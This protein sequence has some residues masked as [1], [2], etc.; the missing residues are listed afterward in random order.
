MGD[1]SER[2]REALAAIQ[3]AGT[4]DELESL[5]VQLLGR[6]GEITARLKAVG[7]LPAAQRPAAGKAVNQ[8]KNEIGAA[9][10]ARKQALSEHRLDAAL[11]AGGLDVSLPGRGA[12][13]GAE[14]PLSRTIRRVRAILGGAG[15]AVRSGPEVEDEF[16]NFT[17]LNMP[18]E[19]PARD[20]HDTFYLPSGRLLRTHTSPVQIRAMLAEG[21]PLKV[22]SLGRVFRRDSDQTHTPVFHQ[23]EGLAVDEN[24]SLANLKS[25]L[26]EFAEQ[27]F[28][29]KVEVRFRASYFPF[30]EP[31][32]EMDVRWDSGG[33][34]E[35]LGCGLVHPEVLR[36]GGVDPEQYTG[37]AFGM[38]VERMAML[39]YGVRDIRRFFDNDIRFL[40]QF[41]P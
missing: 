31:S 23:V 29:R 13:S 40:A 34:L 9:I 26:H 38:G 21:A 4:L 28:E 5:R 1:F 37:Y 8:A 11:S 25:L 17:A 7:A 10:A 35:I 3:A 15:F 24:L 41:A 12:R 2:I 16:H 18:S 32:A 39:R 22:I 14:H 30:T 27:F 36:H 19:H 33:W 6:K 20:M